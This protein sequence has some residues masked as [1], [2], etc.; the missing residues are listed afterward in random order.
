MINY[1]TSSKHQN[2][3]T[4]QIIKHLPDSIE[5][6]L[7]NNLSYKQVFNSAKPEYKKA[8]KDS[9]YKK[10]NI[11]YRAQKEQRKKNDRN[12]KVICFNTLYNKQISTNIAKRSLNLLDQRF[13][14]QHRLCKKFNRNNLK[15]GLHRKYVQFYFISQKKLL[16]IRT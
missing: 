14:K 5:E 10:V 12:R 3:Q 2:Y 9:G 8:L 1:S 4:P 15:V 13:P 7:S 16:N 11:K 6:R